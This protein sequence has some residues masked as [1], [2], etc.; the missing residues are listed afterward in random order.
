MSFTGDFLAGLEKRS[1]GIQ[2]TTPTTT[3]TI[4][5]KKYDDDFAPIRQTS[6][7]SDIAPIIPTVGTLSSNNTK[8]KSDKRTWFQKSE[9][10]DDGYDFGDVTKT[11][12]GSSTDVLE[13]LGTGLIGMGEKALDA[14]MMLGTAMSQQE[15]QK[16]ADN[17]V[18]F[19]ALK[20]SDVSAEETYR[21]YDKSKAEA[22]KGATEFVQKDLYDEADVAK[23]I[24]S[25]PFREKTGINPETAS[26][27][28]EKSD[29][30]VQSGGEL[31]G[32]TGL[33]FL[34]VP[35]FV[36]SGATA[37]GGGTEQALN[38]GATYE[39]AAL[40]GMIS[41]GAEILTEKISGSIKFGGK[42]LDEALTKPLLEAISNKAV[43]T[44][45]NV[46]FDMVGE[47][48]EEVVSSVISRLGTA[49]YKEENLSE[50]LASEEALNEYIEGFIGGSF[51][52]GMASTGKTIKS[53][54][55]GVDPVTELTH[56]EQK[57]VDK[58]VSDRI[59]EKG[60]D[61]N[62]VTAK[63]KAEIRKSVKS[64]LEKGY[65]DIDTIE[66]VL[67]GETYNKY[68]SMTEQE[69]SLQTKFD[70]LYKMKRGDMTT[71]QIDTLESLKQEL[72]DFKSKSNKDKVKARLGEEVFNLVK[73]SR[74]AESYNERARLSEDFK[75]DFSK[76]EGTK[77]EDAAKK[78]LEN[79]IEAGANNTNRVRDLV[80]MNAKISGD[81]GIVFKY[82][83]N[84]QIKSDFIERQTSEINKIEAIP[85]E[86]RS[87]EQTEFLA[88]MKDTL[89]KVES[90]E[91]VV[92]GDI[93]S[94]G[95]VINL[96]S[97][98]AL[99][100]L[101][102]HEITHSLE[103]SKHYEK[104]RDTLFAYAKA[105]GVDIDSELDVLKS[106][107]QGVANAN[108]EAELVA[109]LVGDYLF[110][111][112]D[113]ISNL[114][115]ENPSLFKRIYNE[116]KYLCNV[117]TAGSK[118]ARELEKVKRAFEKAYKES[119]T[120]QKNTTDKGDV[121]HSFSS[122][123]NTFFDDPNMSANDF[124][125][126][127][128]T[129]TQG[130]KDY[131]EQCVNNY[132][133]TRA[134]FDE[135]VA[136]EEIENQ[137]K[138]IVDVAIASK[139]AGYDIYDD[140]KKRDL[141]DSKKRLLFS[142]L[143]PNSEYT[144]SND[145]STICDK[146]K[147]FTAIYDEIVRREEALGVPKGKRFFDKIDNYFYLHKVLAEKGLTQP[148]RQCYVDSMRKNLT[149]M[150]NAFLELVGE[151]NPD[152]KANA[153]LYNKSG[154]DK[155]KIKSNNA[156]LRE[157]VLE[158]LA[159]DEMPVEKLSLEML[160]TEDGL[161]Q[162]RLQHPLVYEAFNS[163]YGQSKPKMPKS[164]TPFRFGE[165]TALLTKDN[166]TINQSLVDKINSTGGFRLQSYSDF[167]IA[168]FVDTLQVIFEAGTLGLSGHA[169]TKVPA[170]LDATEGTNLK[171]NISIFMYKDGSKWKIDKNDSFPY[172]LEEIY[173]I[174]QNDK[175]GNTSIIAV[176]QNAEMSAWVMANDYIGYF[177]PFHKSGHKMGTVRDTDV[178][179][180]DGRTVKGYKNT[181]DHTKQQTE[182][183]AKT[184][185]DH[186]ANTKVKKPINIYK[187]WDFDNKKNLSKN[188][189]IEKNVKAYIDACEDMGYLPKFRD[190]V[191]NNDKVLNDVLRYSKALGFVSQDAT[192]ED[193]SFEYKGYTI[194]YGYYKC[195]GDFGIFTPDGKASP[196]KTLSLKDYDFDKAVNF[197]KDAEALKRNEILQQFANGEER[198]K[199]RNSNLSAEELTEIVKQKRG[200]V[201]ESIV[202]PA[203]NSLSFEGEHPIK[204]GN[205]NVY[206]KDF[207]V[208]KTDDIAPK[209]ESKTSARVNEQN[210]VANLT[211][212]DVPP[213]KDVP[214]Y[215]DVSD[216]TS[217][218]DTTLKGI[219]QRL[220]ETLSLNAKETKAIQEVVQ[221]YS[222]TGLPDKTKIFDD[223]K[224]EFGE[225]RWKERS[226][227]I[228]EVKRTLK[229]FTINV[230]DAIKSD[231]PDYSDWRRR[232]QGRL[233]FSKS[234]LSV[235][236]I[237][238]GL[239]VAYPGL[240]PADINNP[241]D[242]LLRMAEIADNDIYQSASREVDNDI[243]QEATD[244]IYDEVTRYKENELAQRL[245]EEESAFYKRI[246]EEETA[247]PSTAKTVEERDADKIKGFRA[248]ILMNQQL[249]DDSNADFDSE[250][251]RL[252][253][254]Y[255]A[256]RDKNT[257]AANNILRR[258][259][260][261]QRMKGSVD[262]DYSKRIADL[263][264]RIEKMES[265]D[266]QTAAQ[267][268]TKQQE[269]RSWAEKLVG[270]TST[271]V[272]KKVGISY[273]VN[274]LRRN[275]RD[276][277]RDANGNKDIEKANAIYDELQGSYN[278]NEAELKRESNRIKNPFAKMKI[279]KA[280]DAYIQMLGELRHN[281]DTTLTED[282]VKDFYENHKDKIDE[283]KVDKVIEMARP[284]Y[285]E[286][287]T[288]VNT[289]L[290]EQGMK[291]IPYRQGYFPHFTEDKQGIL[292]KLFNWK[293]KNN[294]IPTDIAGL[295]EMFNPKR[296][297]Q[298][299]NKQRKGDTTDYSFLKGLDTYVQGSLDWVYHIED[300]QKRRAFENHIRYIHSEKGVQ[301]RI[302]AIHSNEEYD[303]DEMQEQIDLVYKEAR[304]PLNNFVTDFRTQTN[305][306]A[307]K[308]SSIDRGMEE[309]TNRKVY[310]T[311][312]NLSNRVTA[313]MVA[314]SVSSALTNFI[315][316]TQ[317]WGEV[318]PISSIRAMADTI[319]ST[320][321]DDGTI[322]KSDF[323]T[324]RLN[325]PDNLYKTNWDKV[326]DKVGW[327]M[328][329]ID[330]FTSQTVWRSKYLENIS[331]GMS[332]N[333]AI[334]SA[335]QFA[336]DVIGGRSRGNAPTIFDSKNPLVKTLTA[337]Q[338]EVN[339]QYGYMF[340]DMPSDLR[341]ESTGK[342]VK[343]YVTMFVGAYVYNA[344]YSSLTGRDAAF[345][346]I[347][348]VEDL[349]RDLGLG[350]DDEEEEIAPVDVAMN[351]T[352]NVLDE[353]PF[354]GGLL[355]GGRV[356]LSSAMPYGG[357]MEAI[358]GTMQDASEGNVKSL[359]QEWLNPVW[360]LALP[361]G[362]GQIKKS[363]QGL[364]MF[365]DDL[366]IAGSY[367]DSG[368]LR[369]PVEDTPKN[370]V[371][372]AIF[373]QYANKNAQK[374]FDE[375]F[376]PL[377]EKQI[378]EYVDS[379]LPIADYWKYREGLK[380][381]NKQDDK[382]DYI[383]GL[384]ISKEQKDVLKSYLYDEEGYKEENPE[385]YA[386]LENE[387]IGFLGYKELDEE[388]Q[389]SWSWAFKHQDEYRYLKEN[390]VNPE[391]YSV[392]RVPMLD[393]DDEGDEAYT[394]AFDNPE[395]ATVG[396]VFGGGVKEYKQYSDYLYNI[397]A[398]KDSNGKSIS[399]TAKRKKLEYIN[400][401]DI[402]Y[403]A[404]CILIKSCYS[405]E[406]KYNDDIVDYL[407]SRDDI[408][409]EE[410]ITILKELGATVDDEGYV[411]W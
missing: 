65:I 44:L 48:A 100:S 79:A 119:T 408:S 127:D 132:R 394:W 36:T 312:T 278:H 271:W 24:I 101:T 64:D 105:K 232:H 8:K 313:N 198:E 112:G 168:N 342:L 22:K 193:I 233:N 25:A 275:L 46:G 405:S 11:I 203:K 230:S 179:T 282:V 202:A 274:T 38:E 96:D 146:S 347:G 43:R 16:A 388:T 280:E 118:E 261:L 306:L 182:V 389:E 207:K 205:F 111:D 174:V 358:E 387:G 68:K 28:G 293:T 201:A 307:G 107:Y 378:K 191:M 237:Y 215:Y 329:A 248:E 300:I 147:N 162:L 281:P 256:K 143:E 39:E 292:G 78:T 287:L 115:T 131:V 234:G 235:D 377:K 29:A 83:G 181:I 5:K 321:R 187:F 148:C 355:G 309:M 116:I 17:E 42:T 3:P 72:E 91:I 49:L 263:E 404:K 208:Q 311:M 364:K 18:V 173:D 357:I 125:K 348:I 142:S 136:R 386:F 32:T 70:E 124:K 7:I 167:Q 85:E 304:N 333:E 225:K 184:T 269:Y 400:N 74:L 31:L 338:L 361:M 325:E 154:K 264:S 285:D 103:K 359:T 189:L 63:D 339:N 372:A 126:V 399:G 367:T 384:D 110:T 159:E 54:V 120:A 227:E 273:K 276:I 301:E 335:D 254:E 199:Y 166:G 296:S 407:N 337:F 19:N 172:E 92:N 209:T 239:S 51:L 251:S 13:N 135:S 286:L 380:K 157:R 153:Q 71:E 224:E 170:F 164:A 140:N 4:R 14:M 149:P 245:A 84:E 295:T 88:K 305:T 73:D 211:D 315:P 350:D 200:E 331:N 90:G 169:Y 403:G 381:F 277:V 95:I 62:K 334:K 369:F 114:S 223:I 117:A 128:Y 176:S 391:D 382:V 1:K 123:A 61:G 366:P 376:A 258:I 310:S 212:M 229:G 34:G 41:A 52:G 196:H 102:G 98:K 363:V 87:E 50:I 220:R 219:G 344:L 373:G 247:G 192:I 279:T 244:I 336:E 299:F 130:Y 393:F 238:D 231:I 45:A 398:D 221:K 322:N 332:E 23:R 242:Q 297:W 330:S 53:N 141:R 197:F 214:I 2:T 129:Q 375:G 160:T 35:W 80:E 138:G 289:V 308:K 137:I 47:G 371:K 188:E 328:E 60:K 139:K 290:A 253:A 326:G 346:P 368:N 228:A 351:L 190:Y 320:I 150:A 324:N 226:E 343:G 374:Y 409:R 133:Q 15:M 319:K 268:M 259:E 81:T 185:S 410:T 262:A 108:P 390:G 40:S 175:S 10:F 327:L 156:K 178:V 99:N 257:K 341:N 67:G 291:E 411:H 370:R 246:A 180:D 9:Y 106:K 59:A 314:G 222:T 194:P 161:A 20:G 402:D 236:D 186:K 122:V 30:V 27:F 204:N 33:Q 243:I 216:T 360:Y 89:A 77:Y 69:E 165:L 134:D 365:D 152:N 76:I 6:V 294:E 379:D 57:V 121:K 151:T 284:L 323:L 397:R 241:T 37:F 385:K 298:S 250:I 104:L 195:L 58:L 265:K 302:D 353:L 213:E 356:P 145:I 206:G 352:D 317:S 316:I 97:P 171:R 383:N 249:R 349:L 272:D 270:D 56:N 392:Y 177:I 406:R 318:S 283:A 66:S 395:K 362:G 26:V 155:G 82:A 345:D 340:K 266:F 354:V 252:K 183:W 75:A 267:R 218:D 12:L 401:L 158:I 240:F 210:D 113:F 93:T 260:R 144:T 303:A 94:D 21:K 109:D 396:K 255:N 217:I 163:F 55:N 288:R 86:Q